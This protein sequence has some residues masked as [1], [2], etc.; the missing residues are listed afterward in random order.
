MS[1]PQAR[2]LPPIGLI[3]SWTVLCVEDGT[4][5]IGAQTSVPEEELHRPRH[6]RQERTVIVRVPYVRRVVSVSIQSLTE[7]SLAQATFIR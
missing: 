3:V 4:R 2:T 6:L 5:L 1:L 7:L